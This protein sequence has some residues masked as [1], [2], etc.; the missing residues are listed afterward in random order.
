MHKLKLEK[1]LAQTTLALLHKWDKVFEKLSMAALAN[2]N[3]I[4]FL[5]LGLGFEFQMFKLHKT[6]LQ[7]CSGAGWW[8]CLFWEWAGLRSLISQHNKG[9]IHLYITDFPSIRTKLFTFMFIIPSGNDW[10]SSR[11]LNFLN[12]AIWIFLKSEWTTI[13]KATV[14]HTCLHLHFPSGEKV[15]LWTNV[16]KKKKIIQ[17]TH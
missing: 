6:F 17:F 8:S 1:Y 12:H 7:H 10:K 9:G 3:W 15:R 5:S 16:I 2:G 4:R 13:L 14:Y 11:V